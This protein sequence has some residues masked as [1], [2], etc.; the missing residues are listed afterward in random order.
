[1]DFLFFFK[2]QLNYLTREKIYAL[3]LASQK[4]F[5]Y[6]LSTPMNIYTFLSYPSELIEKVIRN[7]NEHRQTSN[8]WLVAVLAMCMVFVSFVS[9]KPGSMW[10]LL[11][12]NIQNASAQRNYAEISQSEGE[13][14]TITLEGVEYLLVPKN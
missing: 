11:Q 10:P 3:M 7:S 12:A 6:K 13:Y 2:F 5:S 4:I 9:N 1:M 8:T 14:K